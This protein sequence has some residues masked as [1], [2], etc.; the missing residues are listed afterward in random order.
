MPNQAN[1]KTGIKIVSM[2]LMFVRKS[3][4]RQHHSIRRLALHKRLKRAA[5]PAHFFPYPGNQH[6][7]SQ[8]WFLATYAICPLRKTLI[9]GPPK[10]SMRIKFLLPTKIDF[11]C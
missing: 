2:K 11:V 4:R 8:I 10:L 9:L 7:Q 5:M 3:A 1:T 6:R